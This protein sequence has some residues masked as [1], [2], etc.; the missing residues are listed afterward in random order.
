M[1]RRVGMET[2][3]ERF[4]IVAVPGMSPTDQQAGDLMLVSISLLNIRDIRLN[5]QHPA[6][7]RDPQQHAASS[8]GALTVKLVFLE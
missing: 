3:G 6:C 4:P 1:D 8:L 5:A 7:F 2:S